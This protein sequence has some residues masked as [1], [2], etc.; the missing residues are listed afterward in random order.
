MGNAKEFVIKNGT[1]TK[2]VGP[3]GDVVIPDGVTSICSG[4]FQNCTGLTGV[5]IPDSVTSIGWCAFSGCTGL[6]IHAPSGSAAEEYA[7]NNSIKFEA[8]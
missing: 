3:G 1:L 2:Y 7:R 6:T 8:I 4:A 5:T